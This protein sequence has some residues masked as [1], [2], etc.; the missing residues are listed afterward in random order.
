MQA[1]R[2]YVDIAKKVYWRVG[3]SNILFFTAAGSALVV[4]YA[5][6]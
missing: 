6:H 4:K 2:P 3:F 5:F 1:I